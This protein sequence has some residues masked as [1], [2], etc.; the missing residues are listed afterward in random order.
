MVGPPSLHFQGLEGTRAGEGPSRPG[1]ALTAL[2]ALPPGWPGLP[3][4]QGHLEPHLPR[5]LQGLQVPILA[6]SPWKDKGCAGHR[7]AAAA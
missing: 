7:R 3:T 1:V 2:Y 5:G 4:A 6:C